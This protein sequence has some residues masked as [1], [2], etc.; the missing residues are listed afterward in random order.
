MDYNAPCNES[1]GRS[2]RSMGRYLARIELEQQGG[3]MHFRSFCAGALAAVVGLSCCSWASAQEVAGAAT[4]TAR[5]MTKAPAPVTQ[6]MLD[7]AASDANN[8]IHSNGSYE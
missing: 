3:L 7:G 4:T 5:A 6:A 1:A 2:G 8:W